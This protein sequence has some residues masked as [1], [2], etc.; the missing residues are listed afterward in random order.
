MKLNKIGEVWNS[1]NRLL[2]DFIG[3]LS[4]KNFATMATWRNDFSSLLL[5]PKGDY[6]KTFVNFFMYNKW[7]SVPNF[8]SEAKMYNFQDETTSI[9]VTF[10]RETH[11]FKLRW[12]VFTITTCSFSLVVNFSFFSFF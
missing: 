11:G 5:T 6:T 2:S 4:S 8:P 10:I 9:P 1:A 7:L 3:L 12:E